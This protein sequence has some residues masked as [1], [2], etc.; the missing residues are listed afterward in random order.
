MAHVENFPDGQGGIARAKY[1]LV[2]A[3]P[4]SGVAFL[5][6]DDPYVGQFGRDFA[7]KVVYFGAGPCA[8]PQITA[9]RESAVDSDTGAGACLQIDLLSQGEKAIMNLPLVG[10]HNASNAVAALAVA[11]EADVAL[12][13]SIKALESLSAGE[14]RGEILTLGGKWTGVTIINDSYNSNPE[15]LKS[16]IEALAARPAQRRIL[17]AGEMLELGGHAPAL[18]AE[19]GQAAATAGIDVIVGVRG[20]AEY[21]VLAATDADVTGVA[22]IFLPDAES[23]GEWLQENLRQGDVVLVKGSRG[24]RLERAIEPLRA[25]GSE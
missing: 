16:M 5:N 7:G 21:L 13:D 8:D 22:A 12:E 4:A 25:A 11:R 23:A 3:L 15:A 18:H 2:E 24:V 20:N 1:E 9:V 14:K 17:I 6:C 19:C 10:R